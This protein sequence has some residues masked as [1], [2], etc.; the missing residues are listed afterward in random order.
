MAE[1]GEGGQWLE[2]H[3]GSTGFRTDIVARHHRLTV[4]EPESVGGTDAGPTPYEYILTALASCT[5]MT[6]HAYARRKSW[7]LESATVFVRQGRSHERDCEECDTHT[8]GIGKIERRIEMV[9][10]L[11]DEQRKRILEIAERCPIKQTLSRG[12]IVEGS[13]T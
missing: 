12:L 7:P 3:I 9:G 8:V 11:T 10:D 2:A 6:M 4:D 5:V 13:D 1:G